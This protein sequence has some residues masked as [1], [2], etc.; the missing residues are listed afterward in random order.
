[1]EEK[2]NATSDDGSDRGAGQHIGEVV[3]VRGNARVSRGKT[4][5]ESQDQ[6]LEESRST[7]WRESTA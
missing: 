6:A 4:Q 7:K 5:R 1:M 3:T 2:G